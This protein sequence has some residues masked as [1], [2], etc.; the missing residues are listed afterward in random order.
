[1]VRFQRPSLIYLKINLM[2]Q[3]RKTEEIY[4]SEGRLE[5]IVL[6]DEQGNVIA[7]LTQKAGE[8][9]D[10]AEIM[11]NYIEALGDS[12]HLFTLNGD[13]IMKDLKEQPQ[14][15]KKQ[16]H[17]IVVLDGG[18]YECDYYQSIPNSHFLFA[19][20]SEEERYKNSNPD[21]FVIPPT[22]ESI[23][24][25][26][27]HGLYLVGE[28]RIHDGEE[29][30]GEIDDLDKHEDYLYYK[31][32]D[33]KG[34]LY[35]GKVIIEPKYQDIRPTNSENAFWVKNELKWQLLDILNGNIIEAK[36]EFDEN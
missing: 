15:L 29:F 8:D 31:Q 28:N 22:S 12:I 18:N 5:A 23:E 9:L 13:L 2:A 16:G 26:K 1:M 27:E 35:K 33:K 36:A 14:Y 3:S 32:N 4:D 24:F 20:I 34:L 11:G 25:I 7:N 17:F 10:E 30:I 6:T 19:V 21:D